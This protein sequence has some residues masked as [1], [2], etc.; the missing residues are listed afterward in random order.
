MYDVSAH[1]RFI[2]DESRTAAYR[3]ALRQAVKPGSVVVDIGT[4]T[5]IFALLACRYGASHVYAIEA[6]DIIQLGRELAEANSLA[7]QITFIQGMSTEVILPERADVIVSDLRGVLP[8]FAQHLPSMIAAVDRFLKPGGIVIPLRDTLWAGVVEAP[9]L[10]KNRMGA[11]DGS[12]FG[13]NVRAAAAL[14]ASS[15]CKGR[16][17]PQQLLAPPSSWMT[18][19][20][21]NL[22]TANGAGETTFRIQRDGT[23]HGLLLWFDATVA[24]GAHFSNAPGEPEHVYGSAFFPWPRPVELRT[25][26]T[27]F[28]SLRATLVEGDYVWSWRSELLEQGDPARKKASFRQSTLSGLTIAPERLRMD[29]QPD[30]WWHGA[31]RG[32]AP[33]ARGIPQAIPNLAQ[34]TGSRERDVSVV[35]RIAC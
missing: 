20:Y 1:G 34:R 2:A 18:L 29:S 12:P 30:G 32:S 25:D 15:W 10:Y 4:G 31:G 19:D 28:V 13:L 26:D 17:Q 33:N 35:Q 23:G 5:G 8:F 11:W 21:S 6:G 9:D 16:V 14:A 22:K 7:K 24:E 3:N 27:V